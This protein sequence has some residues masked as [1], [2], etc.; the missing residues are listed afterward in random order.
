MQ[1]I[2]PRGRDNADLGAGAFA[3]FGAVGVGDDV[4]LADCVD[5]Q[6]L[7]TSAAGRVIDD[8]SAGL[9]DAVQQEQIL[10]RAAAGDRKHVS[11]R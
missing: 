8:R 4:E 9:L 11:D 6:Q 10:L 3:V 1:L 5:A 2:D 7:P